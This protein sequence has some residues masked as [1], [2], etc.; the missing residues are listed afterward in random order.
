MLDGRMI[1]VRLFLMRHSTLALFAFKSVMTEL[2]ISLRKTLLSLDFQM[3][4]R[5]A[6][7]LSILTS[8]L[9]CLILSNH[10]CIFDW[11]IFGNLAVIP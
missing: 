6:T 11:E 5:S 2:G 8:G 4:H 1:C 10:Y 9:N 7:I 3:L